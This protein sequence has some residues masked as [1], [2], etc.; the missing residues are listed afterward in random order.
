MLSILDKRVP[1]K[2]FETWQKKDNID[3]LEK[4]ITK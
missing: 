2:L 1:A 4:L 3:Y